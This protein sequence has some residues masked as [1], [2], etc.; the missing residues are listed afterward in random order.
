MYISV[1]DLV[2]QFEK[3]VLSLEKNRSY[4]RI[5]SAAITHFK[6]RMYNLASDFVWQFE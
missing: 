5:Q 6:Y 3:K 1:P 4:F 2:W